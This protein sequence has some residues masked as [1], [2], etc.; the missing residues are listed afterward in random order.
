MAFIKLMC[1]S[2]PIILVLHIYRMS[3]KSRDGWIFPQVK[4]FSKKVKIIP[5]VNFN[6][7]FNGDLHFDLEIDLHGLFKVNFVLLNENPLFYIC[8]L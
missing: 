2:D 8:N 3:K 5:E 6:D 4:Y 1:I 7:E